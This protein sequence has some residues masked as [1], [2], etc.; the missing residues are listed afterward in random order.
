VKLNYRYQNGL[1]SFG[2][3]PS[4]AWYCDPKWLA[5]TLSRHKFAAKFLADS[6]HVLEIGCADAFATRVVAHEV[7][8]LT[9]IVFDP[10]FIE[11]ANARMSDRW[12][13]ECFVH[14][15][16]SGHVLGKYDG[17]YTLNALEHILPEHEALFLNNI[18]VS[19]DIHGAMALGMSSIGS[20]RYVSP[21]YKESLVNCKSMPYFKK[22][23]QHNFHNVFMF[24]MNDGE[25]HTGYHKMAYYL[26]AVCS[27]KKLEH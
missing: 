25:V 4:L 8:K 20:Q 18:V 23:M 10:L 16:H 24:S 15:I 5:F 26:F 1:D 21:M 19:L 13:F 22:T 2:L 7:E 27:N 3:M 11:D 6:K 17:I 14:G 12:R 9:A